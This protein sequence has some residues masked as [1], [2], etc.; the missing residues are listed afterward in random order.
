MLAKTPHMRVMSGICSPNEK[1]AKQSGLIDYESAL[2]AG[3]M[4]HGP[5]DAVENYMLHTKDQ[6]ITAALESEAMHAVYHRHI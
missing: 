5:F 4:F 3:V 2:C 6:K 1:K